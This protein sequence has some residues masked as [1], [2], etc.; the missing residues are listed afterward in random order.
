MKLV[1]VLLLAAAGLSAQNSAGACAKCHEAAVKQWAASKHAQGSANCVNCHGESAGHMQDGKN[2]VKPER[3]ARKTAIAAL[4][5]TC[6]GDGC[7]VTGNTSD[8]Q[9]CHQAHTL[10]KPAPPA[11]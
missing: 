8:C 5:L 10:V 4:C 2:A 7:A 9:G 3:L 11:K 6:H 1:V